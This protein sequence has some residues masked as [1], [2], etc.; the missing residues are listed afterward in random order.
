[1]S[2]D[3]MT[4]DHT[5]T[6]SSHG[7]SQASSP[8]PQVGEGTR[9]HAADLRARLIVSAP[10][11]ILAMLL[12]MVPAWQ[13]TGWQWVV[14]AASIPV[15]TWGAWPFHRAAFAAG[16][17]GSTTM[18][19]LVSLGVISSTLW[20]WWALLWGGAGMLGM[21]MHMS[22]I[23]RA[24]HAGHA[25]IYFEGACMIVVFLLTGRYMEA[26]AR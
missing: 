26:R 25:E 11:G 15:V 17:H 14:A 8:T 24:A 2:T 13:F 12:S 19:T 21:R 18:D 9:A 1:M 16:R 5:A 6:A 4:H 10:L 23:P 7:A 22:L 20:S 3:S